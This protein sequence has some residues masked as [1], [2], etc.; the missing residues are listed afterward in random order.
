MNELMIVWNRRCDLLLY[1]WRLLNGR[2]DY[3]PEV[4]PAALDW[5]DSELAL[6]TL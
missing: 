3:D 6:M 2:V 1:R 4:I 5:I